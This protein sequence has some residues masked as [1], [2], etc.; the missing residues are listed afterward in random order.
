MKEHKSELTYKHI[1]S[2][3]FL[4]LKRTVNSRQLVFKIPVCTLPEEEMRS[5]NKL[6]S[7]KKLFTLTKAHFNIGEYN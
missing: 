5:M 6:L 7:Y 3:V 4:L 2:M 1:F